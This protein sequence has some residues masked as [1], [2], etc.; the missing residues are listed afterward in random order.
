MAKP[1]L[2]VRMSMDINGY[3][4][5]E[6]VSVQLQNKMP[7]YHV[8]CYPTNENIVDGMSFQVLNVADI[9]ETLHYELKEMIL[10]ELRKTYNNGCN[11]N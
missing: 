10:T 4:S 7:D 2:L 11:A 5:I 3:D 9:N 8:L 1:I 6:R